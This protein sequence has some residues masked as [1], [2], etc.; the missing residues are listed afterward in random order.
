ML[1]GIS[2]S[3]LIIYCK[4]ILSG[5]LSQILVISDSVADSFWLYRTIITT[6]YQKLANK[7][8]RASPALLTCAACLCS[9]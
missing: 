9:E 4:N 7:L 5:M 3:F 2:H 8:S 1:K 6:D